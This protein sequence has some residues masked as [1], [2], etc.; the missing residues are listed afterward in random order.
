[1]ILQQEMC[2]SARIML[3]WFLI[4]ACHVMC[5]KVVNTRIHPGY[6]NILLR[7]HSNL[8]FV[9]FH[10]T[11]IKVF[12]LKGSLLKEGGKLTVSV[13]GGKSTVPFSFFKLTLNG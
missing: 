9:D 5:T 11:R 10:G 12:I 13:G 3:P 7:L 1:M 8:S 2:F 6:G 4:L